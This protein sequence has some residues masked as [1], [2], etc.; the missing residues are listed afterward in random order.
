M[1]WEAELM[2]ERRQ[3]FLE[4]REAER[5][6]SIYNLYHMALDCGEDSDSVL[7][8][9]KKYYPTYSREQILAIVNGFESE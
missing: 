1:Q 4:G 5:E 9:M 6:A 7:E 8:R 2:E 3:G